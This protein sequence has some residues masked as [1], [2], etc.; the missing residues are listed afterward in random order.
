MIGETKFVSVVRRLAPSALIFLS[1]VGA[2][3]VAD[4]TIAASANDEAIA[5]W[6]TLKSFM[7]IA[8][9]FA[10]FGINQ[11]LVREPKAMRLLTRVGGANILVVS[12]VLGI[13]GAYFDLVPSILVGI[14]AIAGF[15]FSNLAF[16]WLRSNL[17]VTAAYL[18][19]G[20]WRVLFLLGI[21]VFFINDNVDI[22]MILTGSFVISGL[23]IVGLIVQNPAKKNLV[24]LHDDI[25]SVKDIYLIGSSYFLAAI[26]LSIATYGEN[27]VV[28]Q[29]GT[30]AD[31]AQYFRASVVFLF[32][33]MILNQYLTAVFGLAVRQEESRV[34]KNLRRYLWKGLA[35]LLLMWPVLIAGGYVLEMLVYGE[36]STPIMLATLLSMASCLRL[37]YVLPGSFIGVIANRRTLLEAS[38][39]YLIC[40]LS[41]PLLS[42][43]F[44]SLGIA[45]VI[46][47]ALASI[48][49]W[50]LRCAVGAGLVYQRLATVTLENK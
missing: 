11:L 24:S 38:I 25:R 23:I 19:N 47:V 1:G 39:I 50:T 31:V 6:A 45:T 18:A 26:S 16:Q 35:G 20:S 36:I 48:I 28:H 30:T 5:L 2:L 34:L 8:S 17:Q 12:L 9:T 10:L 7:M 46:S 21:L 15:S 44:H 43:L 41:L 49:S 29:I 3:Y 14:V 42:L 37:L 33:G 32:P 13:I 4:L 22:G 40:A 27:L